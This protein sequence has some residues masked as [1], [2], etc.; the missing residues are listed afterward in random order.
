[1]FQ[2][3]KCRPFSELDVRDVLERESAF[4]SIQRNSIKNKCQI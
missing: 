2:S 1:M 4:D 3:V